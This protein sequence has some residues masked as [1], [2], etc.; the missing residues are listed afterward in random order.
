MEPAVP[1]FGQRGCEA[2]EDGTA[3]A[4]GGECLYAPEGVGEGRDDGDYGTARWFTNPL[5][6]KVAGGGGVPRPAAG[7]RPDG[8][9]GPDAAVLPAEVGLG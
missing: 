1:K 6:W 9:R 3:A 7:V 2:K 5:Q 4:F 8:S